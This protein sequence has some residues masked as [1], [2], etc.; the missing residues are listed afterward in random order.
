MA[1]PTISEFFRYGPGAFQAAKKREDK[2]TAEELAP[3]LLELK[4]LANQPDKKYNDPNGFNVNLPETK[5]DSVDQL[6]L[7]RA[8]NTLGVDESKFAATRREDTLSQEIQGLSSAEQRV[9][10]LNK[11]SVAPVGFNGGTAYNKFDT[12]NPILAESDAITQLAR[13][14]ESKAQDQELRTSSLESVLNN[15]EIDLLTKATIANKGSTFKPQRVKVRRKDGKEVYMDATPQIGGGHSYAPA[16]DQKGSPLIV[17]PSPS[18]ISPIEKDAELFER[19]LSMDKKAA[20]RLS[21]SLRQRLKT[22]TPDEAWS[23]LVSEISKMQFNRYAK[24]P[25]R[26]Y[27]K[28]AEIWSVK[29]PNRPLPNKDVLESTLSPEETSA[30]SAEQ[31]DPQAEIK[32][33]AEQEGFEVIGEWVEGKGFLVRNEQGQKGYFY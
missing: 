16:N 3:T 14:R 2:A 7:T 23:K 25:K 1:T 11:K 32:T 6:E 26:L 27:E 17:P 9:D 4:A 8:L 20:T 13:Y 29:F 5:F 33:R 18:S 30:I 10:A 12:A 15:P 22:A 24:D 21:L 28:A 31:E 19:V